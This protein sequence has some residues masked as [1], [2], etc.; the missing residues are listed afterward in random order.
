MNGYV[1]F[2]TALLCGGV[3]AVGATAVKKEVDGN[4]FVPLRSARN[5]SDLSKTAEAAYAPYAVNCTDGVASCS[6]RGVCS[7]DKTFCL[8]DDGYTTHPS[9]S[10][11]QCNYR[12][13]R[14]DFLYSA[15]VVGT[16]VTYGTAHWYAG[17]PAQAQAKLVLFYVGFVFAVIGKLL[18]FIFE[19]EE[20]EK[21]KNKKKS[22]GVAANTSAGNGA[23]PP[24]WRNPK[25]LEVRA[26]K[27]GWR[28]YLAGLLFSLIAVLWTSAF[29]I[30][31][32]DDTIKD[33]NG[34]PFF[35]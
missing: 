23:L 4:E 2:L 29:Y 30:S 33:G 14:K 31:L 10:D 13:V 7:V 8:C 27:W 21:E 28:V 20:D 11:P 3:V 25:S 16:D 9:T 22:K 17:Y 5:L 26:E 35:H 18:I 32:I 34:V 24:N 6:A 1:L 19:E 12:Q 15:F